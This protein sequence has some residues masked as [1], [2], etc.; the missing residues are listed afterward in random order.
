MKQSARNKLAKILGVLGI[1]IILGTLLLFL[2]G[3]A[4]YLVF[5]AGIIVSGV[6][7]F[8]VCPKL[9]NESSSLLNWLN[10]SKK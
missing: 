6:L 5:W 9:R 7:G 8:V 1:I 3:K 4:N 2:F 10:K